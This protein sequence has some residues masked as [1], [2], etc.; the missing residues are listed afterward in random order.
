LVTG[1]GVG[2]K[3]LVS[4]TRGHSYIR[5]KSASHADH[6][7]SYPS[8]FGNQMTWHLGWRRAVALHYAL[9]KQLGS[10]REPEK[11]EVSGY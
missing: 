8:S 5:G 11:K 4:R 10:H 2:A 9:L 7:T 1:V 6:G 3:I